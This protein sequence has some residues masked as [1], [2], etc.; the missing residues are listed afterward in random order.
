MVLEIVSIIFDFI[1]GGIGLF[2]A[3]M[4]YKNE[5]RMQAESEKEAKAVERQLNV[6]KTILEKKETVDSLIDSFNVFFGNLSNRK[7]GAHELQ[8]Y[9]SHYS[10]LNQNY[11]LV[12]QYIDEI[13]R[14]LLGLETQTSS[15]NYAKYIDAFREFLTNQKEYTGF[16]QLQ[17]CILAIQ[18][19][20]G[21]ITDDDQRE[22]L[23]RHYNKANQDAISVA[24]RINRMLPYL[25]ELG[26]MF[27]AIQ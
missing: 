19:A 18:Q 12:S 4:Q 6:V 22:Q 24:R 26:I 13:Y 10:N 5:K 14:E 21:K 2:I 20:G 11:S 25:N 17:D 8:E 9:I 27:K 23:S 1:I 3:V 7:L 15:L 16:T